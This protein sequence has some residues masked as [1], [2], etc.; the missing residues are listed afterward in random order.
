LTIPQKEPV[1]LETA[2]DQHDTFLTPAEL[3]YIRTHFPN[4]PAIIASA[5]VK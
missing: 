5:T 4:A 1:H 3:F 2:D